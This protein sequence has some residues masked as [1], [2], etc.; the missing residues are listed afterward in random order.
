MSARQ[1]RTP[2]FGASPPSRQIRKGAEPT[3]EI[4]QGGDPSA[5]ETQTISWHFHALDRDHALWG[6][7]KLK[8]RHWREI[9]TQLVSFETITWAKL[10]E[11]AGGRRNGTNHHSLPTEE[12][13]KSA[14]DRL[15]ELKLD[16]YDQLFSLRLS[17]TLRLYGIREGRVLRILW[18]DPHHGSGQGAYPTAK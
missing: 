18:H 9:L 1:D 5:F 15:A 14:R 4:R 13:C 16:D 12:F 8:A 10:K 3:R 17:N 6:W 11:A 2:K 7:G